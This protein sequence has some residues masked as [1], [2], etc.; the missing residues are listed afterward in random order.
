[1]NPVTEDP[2]KHIRF[3]DDAPEPRTARGQ[4]TIDVLGLR[5]ASLRE[6]RLEK[7]ALLRQ[8]ADITELSAKKPRSR[9]L[10]KLADRA[11]E[12]LDSAVLPDA[13]F[14]S[15]AQDFSAR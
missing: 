15:M 8:L 14:S 13:E 2:R 5:R 10:K 4:A 12:F 1:V 3:R 11:Q 9:E 6:D 7:L